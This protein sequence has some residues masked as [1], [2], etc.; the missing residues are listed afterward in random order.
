MITLSS[1]AIKWVFQFASKDKSRPSLTVMKVVELFGKKYLAATNSYYMGLLECSEDM[2]GHYTVKK[3]KLIK[4]DDQSLNF[5]S[6]ITQ[7]AQRE[8]DRA[9]NEVAREFSNE[10][11]PEWTYFESQRTNQT[12]AV[13]AYQMGLITKYDS[14]YKAKISGQKYP[15]VFDVTIGT[16]K[17]KNAA[18]A[19]IM[20]VDQRR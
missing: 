16:T 3:G 13:P 18:I 5:P 6:S 15:V 11:H 20:P 2:D 1:S 10:K 8:I 12:P 17:N 4:V 14:Q 19:I 7:I 9:T